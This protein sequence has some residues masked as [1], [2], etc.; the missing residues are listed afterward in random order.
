MPSPRSADH[1]VVQSPAR[2][3]V[4]RLISQTRRLRGGVDA[5]R[6]GTTG[7]VEPAEDARLRWRRALC[8]LAVHQLDDLGRQLRQLR[9]DLPAEPPLTRAPDHSPARTEPAPLTAA[10]APTPPSGLVGSVEWN[11]LTDEITWSEELSQIFGRDPADG[12]L[13]LDELPSWL[14]PRTSTS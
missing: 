13:P 12:G 4:D 9:A 8:D 2:G 5:V 3:T 10:A 6:R 1:P 14:P 7:D 11:L